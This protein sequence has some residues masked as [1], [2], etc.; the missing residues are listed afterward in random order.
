VHAQVPADLAARRELIAQ[1]ETAR[2]AG[3]HAQALDAATRA[4]RI[5]MTPSLQLLIA[6]E[7]R[8]LGSLVDAYV[9]ALACARGAR[10]EVSMNNRD[11]IVGSCDDLA[12]TLSPQLG[13]VLVALS[14]NAPTD[15]RVF[16]EDTEVPEAVRDQPRVV[17]PGTHRVRVTASGHATFQREVRINAGAM[18]RIDVSLTP[19]AFA[20]SPASEASRDPGVAPWI[21]VGVGAASV[22]TAGVLFGLA[23][24]AQR[25]PAVVHAHR[26][27]ANRAEEV[28]QWGSVALS[29]ALAHHEVRLPRRPHL[30]TVTRTRNRCCAPLPAWLT[31]L[32][33]DAAVVRIG[34]QHGSFGHRCVAMPCV[35]MP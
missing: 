20:H 18:E 30:P 33:E 16:V 22:A 31:K 29:E 24:S 35:A 28:A 25:V 9:N 27:A 17:M 11:A 7:Q 4:G 1:A 26:R 34:S 8:A 19:G 12:R 2:D 21:V 5:R 3:N 15:T 13:R 32:C 10:V 6:Q 23:L 14:A